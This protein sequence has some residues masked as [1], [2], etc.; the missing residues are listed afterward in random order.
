MTYETTPIFQFVNMIYTM[1]QEIQKVLP[2]PKMRN[3]LASA[4]FWL[5]IA[6]NS[7]HRLEY[8]IE[9]GLLV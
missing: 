8:Y 9:S 5:I 4:G 3:P 2:T 6:F 7:P 1:L